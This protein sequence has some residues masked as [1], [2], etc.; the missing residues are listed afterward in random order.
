MKQ[1]GVYLHI[2]VIL[3]LSVL[4]AC[5]Q[6][7]SSDD[8]RHCSY[9]GEV[10]VNLDVV[11]S[12]AAGEPVKLEISVTSSKDYPDLSLSISYNS[13]I[14]IDSVVTWEDNLRNSTIDNGVAYWSFE[15][16][17]GQTLTF[18]R[19]LHFP[20]RQLMYSGVYVTVVNPGRFVTARDDFVVVLTKEGGQIYREG[21]PIPRYTPNVTSPVFGPGTP[22]PTNITDPTNPWR[23]TYEPPSDFELTPTTTPTIAQPYP[24][25]SSP[26]PTP[27][28]HSYP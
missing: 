11:P 27:T 1:S 20:E 4:S 10:C 16:K 14:T 6:G 24:P 23:K 21:T 3:A 25:P 15:I 28:T 17:A 13:E 2:L 22:A 8:R 9:E 7:K 18:R 12:F 26:S 5:S 19:I